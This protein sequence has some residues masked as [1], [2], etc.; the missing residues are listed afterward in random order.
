[1]RVR[2]ISVLATIAGVV[3]IAVLER[4]RPLRGVDE[5]RSRHTLRNIGTAICAGAPLVLLELPVAL[6]VGGRVARRKSG[7]LQRAHLPR[8]L[9]TSLGVVLLDYT[10]WIWHVMT[11][12]VPF[13]WRFHA[14]HHADRDLDASTAF[15]FH[16]V[17]ISISVVWRAA[18]LRVLGI[19]P[20]TYMTWQ[21]L[22]FL[23]IT[24]HHADLRLPER[25]ERWL[26]WIV[27]TP[28][29]HQIHHAMAVEGRDSNWSNGLMLWDILHGTRK[30]ALPDGVDPTIGIPNVERTPSFAAG[31][32]GPLVPGALC[33]FV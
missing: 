31:L 28:R 33:D 24:F 2:T 23:S 13:L 10:L 18:Q 8:W 3:A 21:E 22:L 27:M 17:E 11:H 9:E 6:W 4:R 5:K 14:V 16:P 1:M 19:T 20:S 32:V 30:A 26:S 12:R 7:L 15:R 29:L 25:F